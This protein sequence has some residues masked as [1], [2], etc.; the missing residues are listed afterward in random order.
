MNKMPELTS[1]EEFSSKHLD[2]TYK[3]LNE[4][5][6]RRDFLIR[7]EISWG[8]HL[9]W[10]ENYKEDESQKIFAILYEGI[11]VGNIG[12][13]FINLND[14][15]SEFWTY[16]GNQSYRGKGIAKAASKQFINIGFNTLGLNKVYCRI[17]EY[18]TPSINLYKGLGFRMEGE[19]IQEMKIDKKYYTIFRYSLLKDDFLKNNPSHL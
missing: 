7:R 2:T 18:N 19:F 15:I 11:H 3:W 6:F 4:P 8:N 13:K 12:Y 5:D 10:Y 16:I 14:D 17:I 9:E 1:L